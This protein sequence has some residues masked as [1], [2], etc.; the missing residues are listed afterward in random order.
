LLSALS[1]GNFLLSK[2]VRTLPWV[3]FL[4]FTR[5]SCLQRKIWFV[6]EA[7]LEF[8]V[9]IS[10]SFLDIAIDEAE[11]L[12]RFLVAEFAILAEFRH[13]RCAPK[14]IKGSIKSPYRVLGSLVAR[15][16]LS[17]LP[18]AL[19]EDSLLKLVLKSPVMIV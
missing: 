11:A 6:E 15:S 18:L 17:W 4:S 5:N 8:P 14:S 7:T 19:G 10:V 12:V 1:T 3:Y 13:R 2:V 16:P 9:D